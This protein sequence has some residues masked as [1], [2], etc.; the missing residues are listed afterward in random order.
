[1]VALPRSDGRARRS[2]HRRGFARAVGSEEARDDAG[3]DRAGQVVDGAG[4]AEYLGQAARAR[5][6]AAH[7]GRP[8]SPAAVDQ[9]RHRAH[10]RGIGMQR[11]G[12]SRQRQPELRRPRVGRPGVVLT[13][14]L[15]PPHQFAA[16]GVG[17]FGRESLQASSAIWRPGR[18]RCPTA[19]A[20]ASGRRQTSSGSRRTAPAPSA[21][22]AAP[23]RRLHAAI[24]RPSSSARSRAARS[25]RSRC[26]RPERQP[27]GPAGR[28]AAVSSGT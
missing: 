14:R 19:V 15:R 9:V 26:D 6:C 8:V 27:H 17:G 10:A 7:C 5:S 28:P 22:V 12:P 23:P 16:G 3:L 20:P 21:H 13:A 18:R 25:Q 2:S 11:R 1:M 24:R 4:P